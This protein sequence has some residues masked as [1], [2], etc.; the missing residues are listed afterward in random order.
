[1]VRGGRHG[2]INEPGGDNFF[3]GVVY[4]GHNRQPCRVPLMHAHCLGPMPYLALAD[5]S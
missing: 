3:G 2:S 4:M 5:R 1:M